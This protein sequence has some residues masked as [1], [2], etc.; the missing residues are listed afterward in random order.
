MP[1]TLGQLEAY[2]VAILKGFVIDQNK[3]VVK[4][5]EYPNT[6]IFSV[7]LAKV[8]HDNNTITSFTQR[9]LSHLMNKATMQDRGINGGVDPDIGVT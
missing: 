5:Q 2:L 3:I 1:M 6:I 9:S 4:S 8:D 7:S